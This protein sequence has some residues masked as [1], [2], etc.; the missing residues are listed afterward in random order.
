MKKGVVVVAFGTSYK[1][2]YDK[3]ILPI[4]ETIKDK[5]GL[6]TELAFTSRIIKKILAKRGIE[7]MNEIEAVEKLRESCDEIFLVP[8]HILRGFEYEKLEAIE[9]V[10]VGKPLLETIDDIKEFARRVKFS[11]KDTA[12]ILMGHG[13]EHQ[14]DW[15]YE[16]LENAYHAIGYDKLFV[17]TV[18]GKRTIEDIIPRLKEKG[19][20][21]VV[22]R[23]LMLVA[24]DHAKNDM[25][26]D[27]DDS[28][29]SVLEREG[30]E[31]EARLIG[32]GEEPEVRAMYYENLEKLM[33]SKKLYAIGTGPGKKEYLTLMAV[34]ALKEASV[35][36]APNN[37]G[38]NMALD[39][40]SDFIEGKKVVMLDYPMGNVTDE[41]YKKAFQII[42]SE[43]KPGDVGAF[44][45]IGDAT[46]YSTFI[47]TLEYNNGLDIQFVP[48]IP[49]FLA[50]AN[51]LKTPLVKKNENFTLCENLTDDVLKTSAA[52]AILKTFR[53]ENKKEI[54]KKLK[55]NGYDY[56]YISNISACHERIATTDEEILK[57]ENYLSLI[58]GRRK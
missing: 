48:G 35:I 15:V 49:S 32:L 5:L 21:K 28:W 53:N 20:K 31:V 33:N 30:F 57:E 9:G 19:I 3:T 34:N 40:V 13:T 44:V 55:E 25:A 6:E 26:G 10:R 17:G 16:S 18:E 42:D 14:V 56:K 36:F 47:N 23:P 39:T 24:G 8:L 4:Y 2:T 22:L 45:T 27:E 46:V 52:V 43:L 58:I 54:I 7:F 37:K 41:D 38:K 1:D 50:A 51:I 11:D 29:K 12:M